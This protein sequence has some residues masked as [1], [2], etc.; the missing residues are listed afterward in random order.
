MADGWQDPKERKRWFKGWTALHVAA[1]YNDVNAVKTLLSFGAD[2]AADI[3]SK[4]THSSYQQGDTP[5]HHAAKWDAP[6]IIRLLIDEKQR[7]SG[8]GKSS[9]TGEE[10]ERT[11][12][13]E[14]KK[15]QWLL[16]TYID[17]PNAVLSIRNNILSGVYRSK[18]RRRPLCDSHSR[19]AATERSLF[20]SRRE[21]TS[22]S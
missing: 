13:A 2:V 9:T 5:L 4:S 8:E 20:S 14:E 18:R 1:R 21:P 7:Q 6:E 17:K 15:Q 10:I 19:R 12:S 3:K 22:D 16:E 11:P